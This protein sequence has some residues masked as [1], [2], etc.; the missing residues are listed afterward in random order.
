VYDF[1][2]NGQVFI[3]LPN[4]SLSKKDTS[5][6]AW[7]KDKELLWKEKRSD[8]AAELMTVIKLD[9]KDLVLRSADSTL[10]Y[11]KKVK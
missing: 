10:V 4:D 3:S 8:S 6:S 9:K 1:Q 2:T 11:F 5:S 7:G